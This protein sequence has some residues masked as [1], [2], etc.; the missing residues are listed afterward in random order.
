[1]SWIAIFEFWHVLDILTK[2]IE[3][4]P[5]VRNGGGTCTPPAGVLPR[6][7]SRA[8]ARLPAQQCISRKRSTA[9]L[10]DGWGRQS[11]PKR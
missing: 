2:N 1:M 5:K 10:T 8:T 9:Q 11:R 6:S 4:M 3:K 7:K